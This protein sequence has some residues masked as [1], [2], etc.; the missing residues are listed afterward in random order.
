ML[1][2]RALLKFLGIGAAATFPAVCEALPIGMSNAE[3][4][5]FA[6]AR[7]LGIDVVYKLQP[8]WA[9]GAPGYSIGW[10]DSLDC[11]AL[12]H[13]EANLSCCI[14]VSDIAIG[15]R[16]SVAFTTLQQHVEAWKATGRYPWEIADGTRRV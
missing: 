1:T 14:P 8:V 5:A 2:K 15:Q 10:D 13:G 7:T 12:S 16:L 6:A 11:I 9:C 4:A 3:R